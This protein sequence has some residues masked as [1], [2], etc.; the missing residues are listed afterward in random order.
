MIDS[1]KDLIME[2]VG[3][4][5]FVFDPWYAVH[6]KSGR[7]IYAANIVNNQLGLT[8]YLPE[9]E[10]HLRRKTQRVPFF[11]GYFFIQANLQ[12]VGLSLI[13]TSPGVLKLLDFGDG[14]Q[15]VP[16]MLIEMIREAVNKHSI[17]HGLSHQKF[18]PGDPVHVT[19]GPLEGLEAVFLESLASGERARVLLHFLGRLG[20]AQVDVNSL[21]KLRG[22]P[23][24]RE[25]RTRGKGRRIH[26]ASV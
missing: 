22:E 15:A 21:E 17:C 6:C 14:P 9:I 24:Q 19:S 7:E 12:K 3:N 26:A 8:I 11:P 16:P 4:S 25:R 10:T 23:H 2:A 20:K 18:S 13:N 5:S 1:R